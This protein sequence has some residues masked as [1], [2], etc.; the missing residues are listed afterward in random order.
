CMTA[1]KPPVAVVPPRSLTLAAARFEELP[2]WSNADARSALEAFRR[3]CSDIQEK[4]ADA[5]LGGVGYAGVVRDWDAAC[6][7]AAALPSAD[8]QTAHAFFES[9]FVPYRLADAGSE[10][11]FTG[12]YEPEL[13]GSRTRH[14]P[15]QTPLYGVPPDLVAIDRD[16]FRDSL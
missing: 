7:Q 8:P 16:I 11:L 3:S 4:A 6:R 1:P 14:G 15:Y 10:G 2:G 13:R 9:A 12:Y 5:P